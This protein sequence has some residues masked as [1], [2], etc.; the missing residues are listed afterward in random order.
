MI[1]RKSKAE[2][3]ALREAGRIV[4]EVH[5]LM[6]EMVRPGVSTGELDERAEAYIRS[7]GGIPTFKGYHGFPASLCTSINDEVVHGIPSHERIL[8]EGDIIGIDVGVTLK[9]YVG[10]GAWTYTVGKVD[11]EVLKLLKATE[12]SLWRAIDAARVGNRVS[13][14][15]H[16]VES[17]IAP[18][19]YGI[20]RDYCGHGVGTQ[21]HEA[22]QVPNYGRPR[23]GNRLR[24]GWTLALEPMI[25]MGSAETVLEDDEWTVTTI[26]GQPSA[27]FEHS[28]AITDEGPLVLTTLDESLHTRFLR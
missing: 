10:D 17:Y 4:A 1:K 20:V 2:I 11:D 12:E 9:G 5:Q 7:R 21:L 6:K 24:R 28:I 15:G 23:R 14:I 26:D 18:M 3:E 8:K 22:P 25:N 27:H 13:D 19:G 16:A